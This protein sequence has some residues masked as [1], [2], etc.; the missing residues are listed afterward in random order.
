MREKFQGETDWDGPVRFSYRCN[1]QSRPAASRT[2]K[3]LGETDRDGPFVS[4]IAA[5]ARTVPAVSF[6]V[7]DFQR[8]AEKVFAGLLIEEDGGLMEG[9]ADLAVGGIIHVP[10]G[11]G[12][13]QRIAI[14]QLDGGFHSGGEGGIDGGLQRRG[15]VNMNIFRADTDDN[16]PGAERFGA[17]HARPE[18]AEGGMWQ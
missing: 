18:A 5:T 11:D 7:S 3:S 8:G 2:L 10:E 6:R 4:A 13:E 17:F 1:E 15:S 12:G 14:G 16:L 9:E